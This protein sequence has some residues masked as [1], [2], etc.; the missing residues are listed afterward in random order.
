MRIIERAAP[1]SESARSAPR[2]RAAAAGD[3]RVLKPTSPP[4][5][6]RR[7]A[8]SRHRS[9]GTRWDE[10][11][12]HSA[13]PVSG[14]VAS[15]EMCRG[16]SSAGPGSGSHRGG[17][18]IEAPSP[19]RKFCTPQIGVVRS[20]VGEAAYR[21]HPLDAHRRRPL[22]RR[23]PAH[24]STRS[25]SNAATPQRHFDAPGGWAC[26]SSTPTPT[27]GDGTRRVRASKS[28][29]RSSADGPSPTH[30]G[31]LSQSRSSSETGRPARRCGSPSGEGRL[32]PAPGEILNSA[33]HLVPPYMQPVGRSR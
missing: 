19:T 21:A 2:S 27:G 1:G 23:P 26:V 10:T 28:G 15:R 14:V 25:G 32:A 4:P 3:G 9:R 5:S 17:Q 6:D 11:R 22:R 18:A 31:W 20:P 24:R 16:S 30:S 7:G 29:P 33:R 8:V 13:H 12:R